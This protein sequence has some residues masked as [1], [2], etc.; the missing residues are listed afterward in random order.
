MT[1]RAQIIGGYL[2]PYVRK[3]VVVLDLKGIAYEVDPIGP[4]YGRDRFSL[5]ANRGLSPALKCA[6]VSKATLPAKLWAPTA[7]LLWL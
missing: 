1:A 7:I 4:F 5:I 3:V 6:A 2:S